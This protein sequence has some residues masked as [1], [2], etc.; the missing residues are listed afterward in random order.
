MAKKPYSVRI[1]PSIRYQLPIHVEL[2]AQPLA[3]TIKQGRDTIS[4]Y[5]WMQ[6]TELRDALDKILARR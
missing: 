5:T 3:V 1:D 6:I 4:L 2:Y